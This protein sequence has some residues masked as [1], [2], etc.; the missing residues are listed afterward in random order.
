VPQSLLA[1]ANEVMERVGND[2][3]LETAGLDRTSGQGRFDSL[4]HRHPNGGNAAQTRRSG[5]PG[6]TAGWGGHRFFAA[7]HR[8]GEVAPKGVLQHGRV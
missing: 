2:R 3:L 5:Q 4:T 6:R 7:T 1:R 8:D